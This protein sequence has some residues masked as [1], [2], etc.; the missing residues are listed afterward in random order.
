MTYFAGRNRSHP[1]L[2]RDS[3][4]RESLKQEW[5]GQ[6]AG[7]SMADTQALNFCAL[8]ARC[9][10]HSNPSNGSKQRAN[11]MGLHGHAE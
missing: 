9:R 3:L 5:L 8:R 4:K 10:G 6:G 1:P 7:P 2:K 11:N